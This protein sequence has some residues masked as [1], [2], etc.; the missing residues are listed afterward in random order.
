M[1]E[2]RFLNA[3]ELAQLLDVAESTVMRRYRAGEIPGE[4]V[5]KNGVIFVRADLVDADVLPALAEDDELE[6]EGHP[7][8]DHSIAAGMPSGETHYCDGSCRR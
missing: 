1:A 6:C 7:D 3:A 8:D 2:S 4:P 5:G